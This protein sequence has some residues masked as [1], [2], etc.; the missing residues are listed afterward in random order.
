MWHNK[1]YTDK[2]TVFFVTINH[3]KEDIEKKFLTILGMSFF[4]PKE[5]KANIHND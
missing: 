3:T 4:L 5:C 1:D 2:M